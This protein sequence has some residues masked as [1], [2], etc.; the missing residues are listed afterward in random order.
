MNKFET[1]NN[2]SGQRVLPTAEELEQELTYEELQKRDQHWVE[3]YLV[4]RLLMPRA[5]KESM[6]FDEICE[7]SRKI[8]PNLDKTMEATQ[9]RLRLASLFYQATENE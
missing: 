5:F 2:N 6:S 4:S 9:E 8:F 7:R 1:P 3:D